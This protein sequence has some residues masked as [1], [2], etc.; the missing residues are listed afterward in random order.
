MASLG[1]AKD[2]IK[3]LLTVQPNKRLAA[4]QA[5]QHPWIAGDIA[6]DKDI[7]ATVA[8]GLRKVIKHAAP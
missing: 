7:L 2:L 5:L 8:T 6:S 1:A 3:G 4:A